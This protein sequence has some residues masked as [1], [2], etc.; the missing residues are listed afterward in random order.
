MGRP[1]KFFLFL[2]LGACFFLIDFPAA[3]IA[4]Y[5][6][7][8]LLVINRIYREAVRKTLEFSRKLETDRLFIGLR[9][10]TSLEVRHRLPIP[11]HFLAV[12]DTADLNIAALRNLYYG[13]SIQEKSPYT[14][15]YALNGRKRGLYKIGPTR[16]Q[17][18]DLI[19]NKGFALEIDTTSKV[20]VFPSLHPVVAMHYRSLQPY[21]MIRNSLPIYEDP[22]VI[23]GLREYHP[24]DAMKQVNWK[25]SARQNKL[26]V[27]TYQPSI[28]SDALVVLNLKRGDYTSRNRDYYQEQ[29]IEV[30][31][32]MIRR[33]YFDKQK[34]GLIASLV[35]NEQEKILR[36]PFNSSEINFTDLLEK[37]ALTSFPDKVGLEDLINPEKL[38]LP[39]GVNL[40]IITPS[41]NDL[42]LAHLIQLRTMGH[43]IYIINVGQDLNRDLSLWSIGFASYYAAFAGNIL[44]LKRF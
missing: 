29:A 39:W 13:F 10:E 25:V 1:S 16:V 11:I 9:E 32:S 2:L 40:Y 37:L 18:D 19:G 42:S 14:I 44:N 24:G 8:I 6:L 3:K 5:G 4:L 36:T 15:C 12:S 23:T 26:F 20:V 22:T 43:R 34:F 28:S 27:N 21:G 30:T 7:V 41:M 38:I 31:A 33:F 35:L 17:F